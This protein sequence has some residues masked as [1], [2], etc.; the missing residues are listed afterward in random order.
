MTNEFVLRKETRTAHK[1]E[2]VPWRREPALA[3]RSNT[4][5][6]DFLDERIFPFKDDKKQLSAPFGGWPLVIV[7]DHA[8]LGQRRESRITSS[9]PLLACVAGKER[10]VRGPWTGAPFTPL[11]GRTKPEISQTTS[12]DWYQPR[13]PWLPEAPGETNRMWDA[14]WVFWVI[15]KRPLGIGLRAKLYSKDHIRHN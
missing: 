14:Q 15:T 13:P 2:S 4:H 1:E 10:A 12:R 6:L 7:V 3:T 9:A 11:S 8:G 5:V